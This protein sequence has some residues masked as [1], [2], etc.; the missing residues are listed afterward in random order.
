MLIEC[1]VVEDFRQKVYTKL[2]KS[3]TN[4]EAL[5]GSVERSYS[6]ILLQMNRFIYQRKFL[7]LPL[8]PYDFYAMLRLEKLMEEDIAIRNNNCTKCVHKWAGILN[9]GIL[10]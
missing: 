3:F 6:F 1:P 8:D 2:K 5:L 4:T 7:K 9:T 10:A